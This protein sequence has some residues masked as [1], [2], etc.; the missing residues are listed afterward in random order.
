[1]HT[2]ILEKDGQRFVVNAKDF[3]ADDK[4]GAMEIGIGAG[5][6]ECIIWRAKFTGEVL[7]IEQ[8]EANNLQVT[9]ATLGNC[10]VYLLD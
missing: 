1:M 7:D 3:V 8:A 5:F 6:V 2:P 4:C 9:E 10:P